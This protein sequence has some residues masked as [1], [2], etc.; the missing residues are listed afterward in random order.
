MNCEPG[1]G[2]VRLKA[3]GRYLTNPVWVGDGVPERFMGWPW[4][5]GGECWWVEARGDGRRKVFAGM[6]RGDVV[7]AAQRWL[8]DGAPRLDVLDSSRVPDEPRR[9]APNPAG[10]G[11]AEPYRMVP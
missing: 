4:G 1:L 6:D 9:M 7:A 2:E 10:P 3:E 5:L 11:P 8:D